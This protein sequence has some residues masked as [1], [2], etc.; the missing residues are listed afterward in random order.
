[1]TEDASKEK[2]PF[3]EKNWRPSDWEHR[4]DSDFPSIQATTTPHLGS[5]LYKD[6]LCLHDLKNP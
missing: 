2:I 1:M 5:A 3:P 4:W 6:L